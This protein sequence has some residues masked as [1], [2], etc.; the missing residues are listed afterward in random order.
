MDKKANTISV[1]ENKIEITED[2]TPPAE[3][4]PGCNVYKK[5]VSV[6]NAGNTDAF[7]RVFLDFSNIE[8]VENSY[9]ATS[10]PSSL[11]QDLGAFTDT[12]T[13]DEKAAAKEAAINSIKAAGYKS[14]DEFWSATG[15][16]NDWVFV[17][18]SDSEPVVG[19]FFYYTK[20]IAPGESTQD[21]IHSIC[22]YFPTAG[23]I[24]PYEVL[25][26]AES[27][28]TFDKDGA[29]FEDAQWKQAWEEF[30]GRR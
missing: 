23:E 17:P 26:F 13:D 1:G 14:Y 19:G 22:T 2:F 12:M 9:V 5:K 20:S 11:P 24:K 30:L 28:Q 29:R 8:A 3:M 18:E 15:A 21:L 16:D 25:V 4:T 7:V 6:K 27:V 10:A